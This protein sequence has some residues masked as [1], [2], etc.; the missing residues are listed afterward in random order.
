MKHIIT[1]QQQR[2]TYFCTLM[3]GATI[4]LIGCTGGSTPAE[5]AADDHAAVTDGP[6]NRIDIPPAV[7]QNLGI[8]FVN[9]EPRRV[10]QTLRVPGRFEY[11]PTARREYRTMLSGRIELLVTQFD[12]IE[13]D[14]PLY[15]I[16]SPAWRQLQQQLSEVDAAIQRHSSRLASYGP[17]HQ[18]HENHQAQLERTIAIRGERVSQLEALTDAGGGRIA[19]LNAARSAVATAESELAEAKEKDAQLIADE[20]ES[21][22]ELTSAQYA[23]EFLLSSASSIL[24]V[25]VEDIQAT[26]DTPRGPLEQWRAINTIIVRAES[27]GVVETIGVTNG[28]WATEETN[29]LTVVKPD[30]L[31]FRAVGLQS[32]L[33][34]LRD[35]LAGR[36]VAPSPTRAAGGIDLAD[37]MSGTLTLGLTGDPNERTVDLFIV[38]DELHHWARAGVSAQ[39]EIITDGSAA[40]ALAIPAAAVQADGLQQVIFRRDPADP[41]AAIRI[42]ADLGLSDGRWVVV[43]S[44]LRIGDEVVLDGAFQ[45]MLASAT[46]GTQTKGGHFHADGTFHAGD[47]E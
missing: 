46:G 10:E 42:E 36:I 23:R 35:G 37:T 18:A 24:R 9:V 33:G 28:A 8:T 40:P 19:E 14:T 1:L 44:G 20:T 6:T 13:P 45:L 4:A 5:P 7:R 11:L 32:D 27:A 43:N 34:R 31:R 39:L 15:R 16:D 2:S 29:V 30:M 3:I 12:M 22:S 21:Q 47:D 25:S 38:P 26:V 41:N 17:L